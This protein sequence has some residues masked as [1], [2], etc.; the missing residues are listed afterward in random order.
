A[1]PVSR[2]PSPPSAATARW[3]AFC[4]ARPAPAAASRRPGPCSTG[5]RQPPAGNTAG[6]GTLTVLLDLRRTGRYGFRTVDRRGTAGGRVRA[7]RA[8]EAG[9]AQGTARGLGAGLG[10]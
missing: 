3:S 10:R 8:D 5:P 7:G 9:P 6:A 4:S 2:S 1:R